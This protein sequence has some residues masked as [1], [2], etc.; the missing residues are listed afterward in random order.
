MFLRASVSLWRSLGLLQPSLETEHLGDFLDDRAHDLGMPGHGAAAERV[1][2]E[3]VDDAGDT[4][5][6]LADEYDGVVSE[7][8]DAR[9]PGRFEAEADVLVDLAETE[10]LNLAVERDALF[11]LAQVGPVE[12]LAELGLAAEDD[13]EEL[14]AAHLEVEQEANL[15]E[16]LRREPVRLVD[17]EHGPLPLRVAREQQPVEEREH[18]RLRAGAGELQLLAELDE[19]FR[20]RQERVEDVDG[21]DLEIEVIHCRVEQRRLA[22]PDLPR[23]HQETLVILEAVLQVRNHIEVVLGLEEEFLVVGDV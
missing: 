18:L 6:C 17:D 19:E 1:I 10:R 23:D 7:E 20:D 16:Q 5:R 2:A 22:R 13:L 9:G 8:V 21:V 4:A 11:E 14:A 12:R 3:V 15:F